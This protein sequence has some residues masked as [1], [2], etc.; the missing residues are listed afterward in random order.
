MGP[1][2]RRAL[3]LPGK[4]SALM[5]AEVPP[6][7]ALTPVP[8][9]VEFSVTPEALMRSSQTP[10]LDP[11][12]QE[13]QDVSSK[14]AEGH[15]ATEP[16]QREVRD[17]SER[18][19]PL[20]TKE[21]SADVDT[22]QE[23]LTAETSDT[24]EH[25]EAL[26]Q[27]L[28]DTWVRMSAPSELWT[29]PVQGE[30]PD[31]VP[32]SRELTSRVEMEFRREPTFLI[33][34]TRQAEEEEETSPDVSAQ[35]RFG[36]SC[37]EHT[38]ETNHPQDP[39]SGAVWQGEELWSTGMQGS[40]GR[41]GHV[42][43]QGTEGLE[44]QGLEGVGSQGSG[45]PGKEVCSD[46][47]SGEQ[48]PTGE[49]TNG[50]VGG[51]RQG[52]VH[53]PCDVLAEQAGEGLF[54]ELGALHSCERERG[55]QGQ[56]GSGGLRGPEEI[57]VGAQYQETQGLMG[58]SVKVMGRQG[59]GPQ[60]PVVPRERPAEEEAGSRD[61][62]V[63]QGESGEGS[64][65]EGEECD[66]PPTLPLTA[67]EAPTPCALFPDACYSM[68]SVLRTR[69]EPQAEE[70][71]PVALTPTLEP[72]GLPCQPISLPSSFP[73]GESPDQGPAQDSPQEGAGQG[74]RAVSRQGAEVGSGRTPPLP[75][76]T[77]DVAP[78][79]PA[80]ASPGT[81]A[82][83]ARP[84]GDSPRREPSP[85]ACSPETSRAAAST[86]SPSPHRAP[87]TSLHG[88]PSAEATVE[89]CASSHWASPQSPLANWTGAVQ[90]LRS[91]SFPGSH[92]T[93]PTLDPVGISLSFSHSELPQRPPKP[94]IYGS[95]MPR[96]DRK[97]HRD[98]S[99]IPESLSSLSA[100]GP[101]SRESASHPESRQPWGS[102]HNSAFALGTPACG[103]SPPPVST[104]MGI[105]EPPP[106]PPPEKRH[107]YP[108][109]VEKDSHLWAAA[110]TVKRCSHPPALAPGSGLHGP[111]RGSPPQVPDP[112][113]ARQHRPLP[114]TPD[115][116][117][118]TQTSLSPRLKYNKPL[119]P[120]PDLS[121]PHHSSSS[122]RIYRPLPP[123]PIMDP[124]TEPPPL[125]PK[126][127][128]RTRN[129]QGGFM[130]SGGQAQP[131]PVCQEWTV[132]T[133][134]SAG[135][136]SWPPA[137]GRSADSLASTCRSK[138]EVP[139]M[140][141]SN[142]TT[143]LSPSSPTTPWTLE[144]QGPMS[145][146]WLSEESE[147]P[148]GG[149][150]RRTTTSQ[151]GPSGL[152][153]LGLSRAR[154]PE[155]PSHPHLEKASSWPHRRDP[156]RPPEGCS[157]RA[158]VPGEGSSKHKG[159]NRQ[160][161]RRPSILPE[162]SSDTRGPAMEKSPG[163]SDTVVFREKKPKEVM[164]GF[165]RRCSKLINSSQL[166]YQ[167]YSD[168]VLN[169]EI[170]SQQR[171]DSLSEAPATASPRQ[172]R[173]A[174]VSSESYLQRLS[175]ASSGSLWQEI[176]VVRNST[177][178]LS[179]THEGQKLQ[180]AKFELIVSEASYLRSLNVAVDHFQLSSQLRVTLSN[181]DHQWLFSRLQDVRDVSAMFLSD[182]EE[183]FENNI[184]TFQVCDV[185]LSHAPDFRRVY[186]PYV[187]NQTYQER[188]FQNLLNSNSSFRDVLE[189]LESDPICQRLS[190]KSFLIL[191]FQRITRL[192]LLLQ[193]IL[194]RT[195]P[196]SSEE[197]EATKA[198]H[199]LEELI[200]DCNNNVQRMRRTEELIYLS[201]K[202]EFECKI[203]PL[204]SQS[205]WLVKSGEL[206]A[207]E[208]SVSPGL[209]RK[210]NTR[211]IH[212]HLFNDCLLL[213]RP[214]EGSRFLVFD[215]APFSSIR[216][217]K[218][219]MK[220][221]GPHKNLFRLFL[222]HNAQGTQAEFLFS[223]ET[224]SEK[225][226]WI[227]ALSMP[228]EELALLECYDSPQV[229]CLRA[230][231]PRENDELALE[232]ADVVMVTQQSSDGWLEGM[233]LSDGERGWF[234]LQ[235]VEF[236]SNSEVR[237]QNLKE[238]HRVKMA[239]LQLVGQQT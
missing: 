117:H 155:K 98:C 214:R 221:H 138:S 17:A 112:P 35:T 43:L 183:N 72:T 179:M 65:E 217:E 141:F 226:R 190:L 55:T 26:P 24:P 236:I 225:L 28:A 77:A 102:P 199:A 201:Q 130:N 198:H 166:L 93:E 204:I 51:Q 174:L 2:R 208:F 207:L 108:S 53:T 1:R 167:E 126:S 129:P 52:Q 237:A 119:P 81:T 227:S 85:A 187:T 103:S 171:R 173:K 74:K 185:V 164:G 50:S 192:K 90:H 47:H 228:R 27:S 114:S 205:R 147:T 20:Q 160:G 210:L 223:T 175:V 202:I 128:G 127:R 162:G 188:T 99:A 87:E 40:R 135:R 41:G 78:C 178:L 238:A 105:R 23:D 63:P 206:I 15:R 124:P 4:D 168:V 239:K 82:P 133:P 109:L 154:Q 211:P 89:P 75:P 132:P 96:R 159:W 232:K 118:Q 200:R 125:P 152:K 209:R 61:G 30:H 22:D 197:A 143:L 97:S 34:G 115:M 38:T 62:A 121:Q 69:T 233:R 8:A 212:L 234:P 224:Q 139:G 25:R 5:E 196:G 165:S 122:P 145:E 39:E 54:G 71:S 3:P 9:R 231:K 213:S 153:K 60:G 120:T 31:M 144:P 184:F 189:R 42:C 134:H 48:E 169:K 220:L 66:G 157:G 45:T 177:V 161:L 182:L 57:R 12:A 136:T 176:P 56:Q 180:E 186:L 106:P 172:P 58:R 80:E 70:Q 18:M 193:N 150:L 131:R 215:H 73:A 7:G 195:Q 151:E 92:K 6:H 111:P 11:G 64:T 194:K 46:G 156:G 59:Q 49:Q 218:C 191:P 13:G 76:R 146:P 181:Q 37:E 149:S 32:V 68:T 94:A 107:V 116:P 163:P 230:Y 219:E 142:V 10:A 158:S 16:L 229:Q 36:P 235:Q 91:N 222:R 104:D 88:F 44:G 137:M 203:F 113:V 148:T 140:A 79:G 83:S 86:D 170:Q 216:G 123:V 21:A 101:D 14:W 67:P 29:C 110:P 95:V 100:L 84:P 33:L 19:T